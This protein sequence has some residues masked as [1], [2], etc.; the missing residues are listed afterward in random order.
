M[1]PTTTGDDQTLAAAVAEVEDL[2][3]YEFRDPSLLAEALTHPS[4]S[5]HSNYD[6]LEFVGDAALGLAFSYYLYLANRGVDSG[7]LTYLRIANVST[8]KLARVAVQHRLYRLLRR[9]SPQLDEQ[10]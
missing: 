5:N 10:V 1:N 2:L 3:D 7:T 4:K 8:E 6:R 9:N